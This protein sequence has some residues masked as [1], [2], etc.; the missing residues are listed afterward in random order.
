MIWLLSCEHY[1]NGI[2]LEYAHLFLKAVDVLESHRGY[3]V[4]VAPMF[5]RLEPLFDQSEFY[6]Y[7]RLLIEPNT[8]IHDR[9]LFSPFTTQLPREKKSELI[10]KY[11]LPYRNR[12]QT[13]VEEDLDQGVLHISL[14]SFHPM[15][16]N[17]FRETPVGIG[18]DSKRR[19]ERE[20]AKVWK[21]QIK[22]V[23]PDAK[24]RFNYPYRG[25]SD[26]L[27]SYLRRCFPENYLG[28][29]LEV[30]NDVI[31]DYRKVIYESL[32]NLRGVLD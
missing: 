15:H 18:F 2:P 17:Q 21:E 31:L 20:L 13:F 24:V 22:Q 28:F 23:K 11:Y 10:S 12:I 29:T 7:T 9:F 14:H 32:A 30:R 3:D 26:A 6:R 5:I 25:S 1:A 19:Q 16:G 8:S 27:T 4:R